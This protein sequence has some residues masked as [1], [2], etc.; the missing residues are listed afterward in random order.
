MVSGKHD[1]AD[2]TALI[3]AGKGR[4]VLNTV[5]GEPLVFTLNGGG[6]A[7]TDTKGGV[8]QVTIGDVYQSNG[9]IHVVDKVL[10]P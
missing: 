1:A 8:A 2:L 10:M 3:S 9:V 7:V 5:E 6:I 4:A